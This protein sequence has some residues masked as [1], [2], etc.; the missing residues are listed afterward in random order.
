MGFSCMRVGGRP[1]GVSRPPGSWGLEGPSL[2]GGSSR[3]RLLP[4]G[5]AGEDAFPSQEPEPRVTPFAT[6]VFGILSKAVS[7][8]QSG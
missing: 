3:H 2:L 8:L 5:P 1:S 4:R 7:I 6:G